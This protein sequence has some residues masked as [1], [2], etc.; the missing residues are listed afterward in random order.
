LICILREEHRLKL[1]KKK[2]LR[3]IFVPK[4]EK[5]TGGWRKLC[6][7]ELQHEISGDEGN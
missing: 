1:V 4:T 7:V 2:M 3:R 5:E 6:N